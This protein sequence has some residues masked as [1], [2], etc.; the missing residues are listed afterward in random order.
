[1]TSQLVI[2]RAFFFVPSILNLEKIYRKSTN[3]KILAFSK[4][5]RACSAVV[6]VFTFYWLIQIY[7]KK[8]ILY[9]F[10]IKPTYLL[11]VPFVY[12][13]NKETQQTKV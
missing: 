2:F 5:C 3:K 11:L 13:R 6:N 10:Y 8:Y 7:I 4:M 1:M 12:L 9:Q